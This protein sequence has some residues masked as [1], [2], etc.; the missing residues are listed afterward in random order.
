M[1]RM[2]TFFTPK[3]SNLGSS[4]GA[5]SKS[6][7][8]CSISFVNDNAVEYLSPEYQLEIMHLGDFYLSYIP[9]LEVMSSILKQ[10]WI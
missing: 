7:T 4:N 10:N 5:S 1:A 8:H 9:V 2:K 3:S 6:F